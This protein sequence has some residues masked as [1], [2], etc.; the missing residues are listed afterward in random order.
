M[1]ANT[2]FAKSNTILVQH[3]PFPHWRVQYHKDRQTDR[4]TNVFLIDVDVL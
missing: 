2:K 3:C 4:L 1:L